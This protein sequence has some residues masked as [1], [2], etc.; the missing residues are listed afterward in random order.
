M[1]WPQSFSGVPILSK[2]DM[3]SIADSKMKEFHSIDGSD[4][5]SFSVWKFATRYLKKQVR[6]EW[7]SNNGSILGL[8]VFSN[9]TRLPFYIPEEDDLDWRIVDGNTILLDRSLEQAGQVSI[10]R[11]R[12]VLMHE[13]AHQILHANYY[14]SLALKLKPKAAAYSIQK[15]S[16]PENRFNDRKKSW[17][18]LDWIEWQA[19]Y[20]A[21][22]L[23]MP[24][25][26]IDYVHQESM[27]L[28]S[29]KDKVRLHYSEYL[30]YQSLILETARYFRVSPIVAKLRLESI[31]FERMEDRSSPRID[32]YALVPI[33][34][35][36]KTQIKREN[37]E[38][39]KIRRHQERMLG[40]TVYW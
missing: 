24:K 4:E 9:G 6:F 11:P 40:R 26:M 29:Y 7:L 23:L 33:T 13:C 35:K 21:A 16:E 20:L 34:P 3:E 30:A 37:A 27:A 8:S 39:N 18:D 17:E 2:D 32:P 31:S 12:F 5:P 1:I 10:H 22:A 25:F 28:I 15:S 38:D 36:S 14:R 19:N